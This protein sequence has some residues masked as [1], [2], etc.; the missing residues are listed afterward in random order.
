MTDQFQ[1]QWRK[2]SFSNGTGG[3]C[4]EVAHMSDDRVAVRD[5]KDPTLPAHLHTGL[6]W[7]RFLNAV[8][9]GEFSTS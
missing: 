6:A 8:R 7:S 9:G 4:V 3:E 5:T 1:P 2:S